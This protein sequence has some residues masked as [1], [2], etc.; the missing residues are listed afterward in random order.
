VQRPP[1]QLLQHW[2]LL[3]QLAPGAL[4]HCNGRALPAGQQ[5]FVVP[6]HTFPQD[7]QFDGVFSG[8]QTPLQQP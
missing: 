7:P 6:E 5:K 2:L 8:A 3:L 4:R 1:L